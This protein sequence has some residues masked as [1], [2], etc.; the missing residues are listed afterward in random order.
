MEAAIRT[1]VQIHVSED[2]G[3][4]LLFLTGEEEIEEA[5]RRIQADVQSMGKDIPELIVRKLFSSLPP[6]EQQRIFDKAPEPRYPGG[7]PGRKVVVSTN[8]GTFDEAN[9]FLRFYHKTDLFMLYT[10]S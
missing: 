8:I 3:D 9:F 6:K 5:C 10:C 2:P 1:A 4:I 7:P